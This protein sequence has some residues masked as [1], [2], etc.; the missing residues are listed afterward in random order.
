MAHA[1]VR[2]TC[3]CA[4][5]SSVASEGDEALSQEDWREKC[6]VLE[7]LLIK[8]RMQIIKIRELT[9]EKV[10]GSTPSSQALASLSSD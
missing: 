2:V 1:C 6:L 3:V 4:L 10:R 8:F 9:A 5:Q 7:A